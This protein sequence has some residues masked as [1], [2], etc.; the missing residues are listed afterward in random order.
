VSLFDVYTGKDFDPNPAADDLEVTWN[1]ISLIEYQQ[2]LYL[3]YQVMMSYIC[4][5]THVSVIN[6]DL[7]VMR[8]IT[9]V[10]PVTITNLCTS[11]IS[12]CTHCKFCI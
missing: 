5:L 9:G 11:D 4:I 1:I 2:T 7:P 3:Q 6:Y 8:V 10:L 12:W